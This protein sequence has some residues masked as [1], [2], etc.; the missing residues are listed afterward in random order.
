MPGLVDGGALICGAHAIAS[1]TEFGSIV[2]G[3]G[4]PGWQGQT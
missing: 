2:V 1:R 3:V 4:V